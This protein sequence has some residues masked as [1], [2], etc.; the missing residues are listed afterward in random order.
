MEEEGEAVEQ[1]QLR[2]VQETTQREQGSVIEEANSHEQP[3]TGFPLC[4]HCIA[5]YGILYS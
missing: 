2:L 5:N 4:R 1:E 3:I